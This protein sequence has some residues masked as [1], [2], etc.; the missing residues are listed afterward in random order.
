MLS[1]GVDCMIGTG[2]ECGLSC[3]GQA[4]IIRG[5]VE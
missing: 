4:R 5:M 3:L 1:H 2:G